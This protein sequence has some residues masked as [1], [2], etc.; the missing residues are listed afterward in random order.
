MSRNEMIGFVEDQME[1]GLSRQ[2]AIRNLAWQLDMDDPED[3]SEMWYQ[4]LVSGE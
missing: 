2:D 3:Q 4:Q 1:K